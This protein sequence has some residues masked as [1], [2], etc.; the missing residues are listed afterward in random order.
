MVI[1]NEQEA[2]RIAV[3]MEKRAIRIYERALMIVQ[4]EEVAAGIRSM[5][6]DERGH[7]QRFQDMKNA[8]T[9]KPERE[10]TLLQSVAA[11]MLFPGGVM[12][13]ERANSF[14]NLQALYE[15]AAKSEAEA[16]E[17]YR[18][19]ASRCVTAEVRNAFLSIAQEES[20]HLNALRQRLG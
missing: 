3:E 14:T 11:D 6:R 10:A 13:M 15:F 1:G 5:L 8:L 17:K 12:E 9:D 19:L 16:T 7:L 18:D 20:G 4:D 2:L